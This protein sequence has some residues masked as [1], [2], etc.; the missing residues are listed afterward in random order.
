MAKSI[1]QQ[2]DDRCFACGTRCAL[3]THHCFAGTGRRSLSEKYGLTV[4]LCY[5]HHNGSI[6]G[7]HCGNGELDQ[8]IK[9]AAQ[10]AF[11]KQYGHDK[12][13]KVFGKNYL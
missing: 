7:V 13:M 4:K 9:Q 2:D 3:H 12:F 8:Q 10:K 5:K 11:E 6:N 1:V